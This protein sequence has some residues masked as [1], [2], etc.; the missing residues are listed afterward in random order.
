MP[1]LRARHENL[2]LP[3]G[4]RPAAPL[5]RLSSVAALVLVAG[6]VGVAI[7]PAAAAVGEGVRAGVAVALVALA[8]LVHHLLAR[9]RLPKSVSSL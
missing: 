5:A 6:A 4:P 1:S 8:G 3:L 7:V 2:R 9:K